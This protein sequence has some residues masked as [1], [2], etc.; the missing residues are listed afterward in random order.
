EQQTA[1]HTD[2]DQQIEEKS[3][4]GLRPG[5]HSATRQLHAGVRRAAGC[6]ERITFQAWKKVGVPRTISTPFGTIFRGEID[7][8]SSYR[9]DPGVP[10]RSRGRSRFR[11]QLVHFPAGSTRVEASPLL[12]QQRGD[13][14]PLLVVVSYSS[15]A[16]RQSPKQEKIGKIG[17]IEVTPQERCREV[18]TMADDDCHL[19]RNLS[20]LLKWMISTNRVT[21]PGV[22]A[23]SSAAAA[24]AAVAA[25]PSAPSATKTPP[26]KKAAHVFRPMPATPEEAIASAASSMSSRFLEEWKA[27]GYPGRP[28]RCPSTERQAAAAPAAA[29]QSA[30]KRTLDGMF[31][32]SLYNRDVG[33]GGAT[34]AAPVAQTLPASNGN[35]A[36]GRAG[37][38]EGSARA[39]AAAAAAGVDA[40]VLGEAKEEA[41]A[42]KPRNSPAAEREPEIDTD[43]CE[44]PGCRSSVRYGPAD[45]A[46]SGTR[47]ARHKTSGMIEKARRR[48]A[49]DTCTSRKVKCDGG[50]PSCGPC[51]ARQDECR[52]STRL[53]SGPKPGFNADPAGGRPAH[54]KEIAP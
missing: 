26:G 53:K 41:V 9:P 37:S 12:R 49:C 38:P 24:A 44:E 8:P 39:A 28:S 2:K 31:T 1:K 29:A 54:P 35:N 43:L 23:P 18:C 34:S 27:D 13:E 17:K 51:T 40:P 45:S 7:T 3:T 20:A 15:C 50:Q 25:T 48:K 4:G 47:C 16:E 33:A 22:A 19:Q 36:R 46:S 6:W 10:P 32:H 52:Y 30:G 5:R 11:G 14:T 21:V 42:K